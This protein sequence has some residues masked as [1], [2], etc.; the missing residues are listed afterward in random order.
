MG[1]HLA[2]ISPHQHILILMIFIVRHAERADRAGH[3]ELIEVLGDTPLT[4]VGKTQSVETGRYIQQVIDEYQFKNGSTE[5]M[6][7]IVFSSRFLRTIQ[8]ASGICESLDNVYEKTIFLEDTIAQF[9]DWNVYEEKTKGRLF[10][11]Q[12]AEEEQKRY[13]NY[14]VQELSLIHI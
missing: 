10:L 13:F 4:Q 7:A 6:Q 3:P 12:K 2:N 8:T 1:N 9:K 11:S 14:K 5:K